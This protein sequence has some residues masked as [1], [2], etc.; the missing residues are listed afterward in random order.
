MG[1]I[2]LTNLVSLAEFIGLCSAATERPVLPAL[3]IPGV[4]RMSGTLE[5]IK[6]LSDIMNVAKNAGARMVL[7]PTSA[8]QDLQSVPNEVMGSVSPIFYQDGDAI[9]AARRALGV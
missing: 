9:D 2:P 8:I 5:K 4:L 6:D 7:L 1:K 3:A